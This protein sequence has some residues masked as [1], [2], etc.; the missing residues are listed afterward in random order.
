M[1]GLRITGGDTMGNQYQKLAAGKDFL[2]ALWDPLPAMANAPKFGAVLAAIEEHMI[3]SETDCRGRI[4]RVNSG[5]CALSGFS[6]DELIGSF[7]N[8]V[9]S[10]THDVAFW[11][12]FWK[13]ICRGKAWYGEICNRA[14]DGSIYWVDS[15]ILPLR[16]DADEIAGFV[17]IRHDITD[18]KRAEDALSCMGQIV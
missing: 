5:F 7:H 2:D 17:S 15:V 8:I 16:G 14:K 9:N 10:G 3:F 6:E 4:K 13:T 12:D 1:E 18:R 11:S